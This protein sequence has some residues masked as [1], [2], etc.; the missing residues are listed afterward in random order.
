M[1]NTNDIYTKEQK[2]NTVNDKLGRTGT[3]FTGTGRVRVRSYGYGYERVY[4][5]F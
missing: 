5:H 3:N 4:P 2:Q 1:I